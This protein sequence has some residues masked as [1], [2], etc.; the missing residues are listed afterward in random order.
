MFRLCTAPLDVAKR[1]LLCEQTCV[2]VG[3]WTDN[4]LMG[5]G[6]DASGGARVTGSTGGR[7]GVSVGLALSSSRWQ[8]NQ[9]SI[10]PGRHATQTHA[11]ATPPLPKSNYG[12]SKLSRTTT[13]FKIK[14][15]VAAN[16]NWK[17]NKSNEAAVASQNNI[18]NRESFGSRR[19]DGQRQR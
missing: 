18:S 16:E 10:H 4:T 5:F 7:R 15:N 17:S 8:H 13:A 19:D 6:D 1:V 9:L 14:H 2:G 12:E 11:L 3:D